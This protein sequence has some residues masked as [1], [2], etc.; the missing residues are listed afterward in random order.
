MSTEERLKRIAQAKVNRENLERNAAEEKAKR[1]EQMRAFFL[2]YS[3]RINELLIVARE[4]QRNGFLLGEKPR[5][6]TSPEFVSNGITHRFGFVT[7]GNP[8]LQPYNLN[9]LGIGCEGGGA[10]GPNFIITPNGAHEVY[11]SRSFVD[12][13]NRFDATLADFEKR[14][15]AYVDA[16]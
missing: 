15:Y 13:M 3:E 6:D 7:N 16:L 9:L 4:V 11:D 1:H 5:W 2:Q 10:C 8:F 14:F 12:F